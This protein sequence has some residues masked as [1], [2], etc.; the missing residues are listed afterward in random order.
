MKKW[1]IAATALIAMSAAGFAEEAKCREDYRPKKGMPKIIGGREAKEDAWPWMVAL[2]DRKYG[3]DLYQGQFCGG[4]LIH[5]RWVVTAAHCLEK[6]NENGE[7]DG[8]MDPEE[9]EVVLGVNDLENDTGEWIRV[10][11][12]IPHPSY[13]EK[14]VPDI[15]LLEL[16]KDSVREPVVLYSG[17][18]DLDGRTATAIGWGTTS[19]DGDSY[20]AELMQVD[21]TIISNQACNNAYNESGWDNVIEANEFC[22]GY[23]QGG[24][25]TCQGDSGGPLVI[26]ENRTWKLAGVVSWGEGCA[27]PGLYGV[28]AR[29]SSLVGFINQYVHIVLPDSI[30]HVFNDDDGDGGGGCFVKTGK[31]SR[32]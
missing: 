2:M 7:H 18:S 32:R 29:I 15:A 22:A 31:D 5:P 12:V 3:S 24:K 14:L 20:P 23:P 17:E 25:D 30:S 28:Y 26:Y 10:V 4:S 8:Y 13:A 9:V 19:A 21:L 6:L 27:Q 16:E 1:L 11:R